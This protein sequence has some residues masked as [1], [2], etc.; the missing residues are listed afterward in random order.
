E[1]KEVRGVVGGMLDAGEL[2]DGAPGGAVNGNALALPIPA[3]SF[4]AV[5]AS[6]LLEHVWDDRGALAELVRVLRPGGRIA[7]TV[8]TR[9]PE[10][11]CW[12]L[13]HQYHDI[14]GGHVRTY[15]Q[16]DPQ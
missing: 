7:V 15:R 10:R 5:I 14:P 2:P 3:A 9:W 8:P 12:A 1:L 4:D 6:E 16:A 11:V 13:D